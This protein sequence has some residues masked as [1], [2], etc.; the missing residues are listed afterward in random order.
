MFAFK[1]K[2]TYNGNNKVNLLVLRNL[3]KQ[4]FLHSDVNFYNYIVEK[5]LRKIFL[6]INTSRRVYA[7]NLVS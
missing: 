2:I 5:S 1:D 6:L 4:G 3:L 7:R